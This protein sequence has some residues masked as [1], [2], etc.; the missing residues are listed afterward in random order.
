[1]KYTKIVYYALL[2]LVLF[3]F[4]TPAKAEI[5]WQKQF[6]EVI[7]SLTSREYPRLMEG[8]AIH[9]LMTNYVSTKHSPDSIA[10]GGMNLFIQGK[11]DFLLLHWHRDTS[12]ARRAFISALFICERI[13]AL[14][15]PDPHDFDRVDFDAFL[16]LLAQQG[17]DERREEL[18]HVQK[19]AREL[20][21]AIFVALSNSKTLPASVWEGFE[22][23]SQLSET[24]LENILKQKHAK[25]ENK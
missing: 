22:Y 2:A 11:R 6:H 9:A 25:T 8:A 16:P 14:E 1:M 17:A 21:K 19:N 23:T 3:V 12:R 4:L 15:S 13:V 18:D 24:Q 10:I 5:E 20:S 7:E